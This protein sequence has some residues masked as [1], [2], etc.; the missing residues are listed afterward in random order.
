MRVRFV[1]SPVMLL[2]EVCRCHEM[3]RV[4]D[5]LKKANYDHTA[6]QIYWIT[7]VN[8]AFLHLI[9]IGI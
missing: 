2:D 7:W 4:Y 5:I 3:Q 6:I 9:R 8:W 1:H